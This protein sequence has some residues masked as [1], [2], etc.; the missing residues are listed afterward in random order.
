[1]STNPKIYR[2]GDL[3]LIPTELPVEDA[4]AG[5]KHTLA[6]GEE[7]GHAH[8][9]TNALFNSD[10]MMLQV[11]DGGAKLLVEP[12][13]MSWRHESLNIPAGN[14]KLVVQREYTPEAIRDVAD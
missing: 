9:I 4:K 10:A 6:V 11:L 8:V 12:P 14:Y 2:Q 5:A 3:S 7:S 13:S 1:M